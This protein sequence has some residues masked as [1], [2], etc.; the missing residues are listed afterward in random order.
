MSF[1]KKKKKELAH[2]AGMGGLSPTVESPID[3]SV[4]VAGSNASGA[5]APAPGVSS[6]SL[7][8]ENVNGAASANNNSAR[9]L[10]R[11]FDAT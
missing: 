8:P 1:G 4:S 3:A 5:P 6:S 9:D 7:S 11:R 2:V 10:L